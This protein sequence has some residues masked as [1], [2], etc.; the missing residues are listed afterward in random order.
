[1]VDDPS[2]QG[3]A[4][5]LWQELICF[6]RNGYSIETLISGSIFK[7]LLKNRSAFI[8]IHFENIFQTKQATPSTFAK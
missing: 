1:M 4:L 8:E 5:G 3:S 2:E 6:V 7:L